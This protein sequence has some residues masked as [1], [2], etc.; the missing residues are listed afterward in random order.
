M[1]K[2]TL[3]LSCLL[4]VGTSFA[5]QQPLIRTC[6]VDERLEER[7][8][9]DPGVEERMAR[10]EA[11]TQ[12][13]LAKMSEEGAKSVSGEI[14]T[15]P[16][17]VHVLYTNT[18]NNISMAQIESQID[19]LN[20][21]FRRTNPDRN[22][23][24]SQF[25][26][27]AADTQIQ[28]RLATIDPD[29]N[30]TTG[31]TRKRVTRTNWIASSRYDRMK[32]DTE[33]GVNPWNT[34]EYLNMW[35][36]P[37]LVRE[38]GQDGV[39]GYAQ[40]PGE[41]ADTD[42]LVMV[43][44]Y[45]GTTG[46]AVSPFD[47]GRT[48]THEIGHFLNLRHMWGNVPVGADG[49]TYD[50]LVSDT[51]NSDGP[52]Y[53]CTPTHRSCGSTDMVQNY[54]DYSDDSCMNLFT[55]GQKNR[56]RAVLEAGG[57]RRSLALSNKFG[58]ATDSQAPTTPTNLATTT[59]TETTVGLSWTASTD[60]VGV[61]GYDVYQ[62]ATLIGTVT[63]TSANVNELAE[64]TS[65]TFR[66]KAK[67]AAGNTSAFSNTVS[68]TTQG[69]TTTPPNDACNGGVT[70]TANTGSFDDGSGSSNYTNNQDCSWLIQPENGGTVTLTFDNFN[71]ESGYDKVFVY[72]GTSASAS[73]LGEFSGATTPDDITS[74]GNALF[75][76]F[77]SDVSITEAGWD[78]SYTSSTSTTTPVEDT[79]LHEG[80]FESGLDGWIDGGG[81]CARYS[82]NFSYQ[83][84]YSIRLRDN[85]GT[86]S[87]MT[88]SSFDIRDYNQVEVKFF[89][90]ANSMETGEDFW[91]RYYN[92]SSWSTVDSWASGTNFDNN[93]FYTAT[94]V[95]DASEVT[96][97]NNSRF[98][99]Q[100]DASTN[101][102]Q[103]YIDQVTIT[104]LAGSS[105]RESNLRSL[106]TPNVDTTREIEELEEDLSI[107]PNPV[108]GNTLFVKS[109]A[110]VE[111]SYRI[112]NVVGQNI[113]SGSLT[114]ELNVSD[115]TS[116]IYFLEVND[117][118]EII[119]K[120][121]IKK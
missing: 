19:V 7:K 22:N 79:V 89:F 105:N 98:R 14:I 104:G 63:G 16:V 35:I 27:I 33:G 47:G 43:H 26:S 73:L 94:V 31:V 55:Q 38:N 56:M 46:S 121:F 20:Q 4:A 80:S 42:G 2:I 52:N 102:D 24:P 119:T 76:K 96:F 59:I 78:A 71:T 77:E 81:D 111:A 93:T 51:P 109:S 117:G 41:N 87:A 48:T 69:G 1:K 83:G 100:C 74:T 6:T 18:T 32:K 85:S 30:A 95:L 84:N 106:G 120:K 11:F 110:N 50:D 68:A 67:D 90:Y 9:F 8:L 116:G 10:I 103:V 97:A 21:D 70:L 39:L 62:G 44:E 12:E 112:F 29:G 108:N 23:T 13:K 86:A 115:L 66:I 54:M 57:E 64:N 65:Y 107:Y 92:G 91:L 36:V 61:T 114:K 113:Q 37:N 3:A 88:S 82:G 58:T 25:S 53:G 15:L 75:V 72:D 17:V 40:F 28:F 99:F 5:Q 45:F 49:C 101:S 34:S 60:N 118:D